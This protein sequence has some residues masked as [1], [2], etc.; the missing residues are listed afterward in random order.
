VLHERR[1]GAL[2]ASGERDILQANTIN[3]YRT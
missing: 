3:V 1:K 2:V